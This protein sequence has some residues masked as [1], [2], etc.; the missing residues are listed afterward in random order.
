MRRD[1]VV[2]DGRACFVGKPCDVMIE[3]AGRK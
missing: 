1:P 2:E 3:I